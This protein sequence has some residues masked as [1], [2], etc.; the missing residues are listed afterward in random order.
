MASKTLGRIQCPICPHNAAHVKVKTDKTTGT[1]YPY[2]HC[3]GC[4]CQLHT[5]NEEQ[6]GY[7]L[8]KTR[9]EKLDTPAV[10]AF[11]NSDK[12]KREEFQRINEIEQAKEKERAK[13]NAGWLQP[14][15]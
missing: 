12:A 8:G 4:G 7:L 15:N 10:G 1:A 13:E 6:A 3:A 5:K 14:W 9:P 11:E 2:I